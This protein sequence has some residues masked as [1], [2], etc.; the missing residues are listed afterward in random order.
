MEIYAL[1]FR[2]Y[3][4]TPVACGKQ[5]DELLSSVLSLDFTR[6]SPTS[7][8]LDVN[9]LDHMNRG[10]LLHR[11]LHGQTRSYGKISF[12]TRYL[13][14]RLTGLPAYLLRPFRAVIFSKIRGINTLFDITCT[15][16]QVMITVLAT[17]ESYHHFNLCRC[18]VLI[19]RSPTI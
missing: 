12:L 2:V 8:P 16:Y 6:P 15:V 4:F 14:S 17:S 19:C 11:T 18:L 1:D 10:A 3:N 5:R 9:V 7:P 13:N